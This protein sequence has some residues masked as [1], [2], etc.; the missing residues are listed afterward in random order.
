MD[1]IAIKERIAQAPKTPGVYIWKDGRGRPLY[2]GKA[3]NIRTRLSSYT[4]IRDPRIRTMIERATRVDWDQTPTDIEALILESLLIK[5]HRPTFNIDLRDDKSYFFVA[6]TDESFPQFIPTHQVRSRFIK[7]PVKE[8]IGPFTDGVPLKT[9]LKVLR[10]LLPFCTCKTT[11]HVRCLNAHIGMCPGYCCLKAP[12]S[13]VQKQKYARNVRAVRDILTGKRGNLIS[14]MEKRMRQ[15]GRHGALEE[16]RRLQIQIERIARV[17]VNAQ[18][19]S[20]RAVSATKHHG[21]LEQLAEE[22]GLSRP[23][24]RIEGYDIAHIQGTHPTGAMVVFTDGSPDNAEYRLFNI[25]TTE[26]GDVAALKEVLVRRLRHAPPTG[27]WPLPDLILVDG[28]KAQLNAMLR[29]VDQWQMTVD[30][31]R[32]RKTVNKKRTDI[33]IIALAKDETHKGSYVLFSGDAKVR[34]LKRL[35][36]KVRNLIEHVDKEAHRFVLKHHR[37]RRSKG[38]LDTTDR[39]TAH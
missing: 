30:R 21:A 31:S 35:P 36:Q 26:A 17:F 37:N 20:R 32:K 2:I 27:G 10:R 16:A 34:T 22:F 9:T 18:L 12:A 1:L 3:A 8:F 14:R 39:G 23:P 29:T 25:K 19:F 38:L 28:A 13:A 11:H 7:K 15:A 4:K 24:V 6:V 5:R 33:P